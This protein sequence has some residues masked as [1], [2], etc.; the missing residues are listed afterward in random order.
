MGFT[1]DGKAGIIVL[2]NGSDQSPDALA[3][4]ALQKLTAT[5]GL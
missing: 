3:V 2:T 5:G 4:S 1:Q